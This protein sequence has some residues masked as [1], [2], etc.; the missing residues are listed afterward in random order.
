LPTCS[1]GEIE[2][3][4]LEVGLQA[5]YTTVQKEIRQECRHRKTGLEKKNHSRAEERAMWVKV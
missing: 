1:E 2:E 5:M 3:G 4:S